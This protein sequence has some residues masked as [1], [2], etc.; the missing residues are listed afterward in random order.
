MSD[1][2]LTL[3]A[4]QRAAKYTL[5]C[6]PC[7]G[8]GYLPGE[9][10]VVQGSVRPNCF[11]C[12]GQCFVPA[13]LCPTCSKFPEPL[14]RWPVCRTCKGRELVPETSVHHV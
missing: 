9:N 6:E 13:V 5:P 1:C 14:P 3:T 12:N 8:T 4:T 11:Y 10:F 7:E 2:E